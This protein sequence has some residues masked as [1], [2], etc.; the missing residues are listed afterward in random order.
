LLDEAE[1]QEIETGI[2]NQLDQA[3]AYAQSAPVPQPEEA[4]QG[5][6]A[7]THGELVF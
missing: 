3:V 4:L 7:D 2:Q 5:V 1:L 6:Y